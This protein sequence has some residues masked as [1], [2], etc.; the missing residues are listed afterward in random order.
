MSDFHESLSG[1]EDAPT[2]PILEGLEEFKEKDGHDS[3]LIGPYQLHF[4]R[5][6]ACMIGQNIDPTDLTCEEISVASE[7]IRQHSVPEESNPLGIKRSDIRSF[8]LIDVHNILEA[9]YM[10]GWFSLNGVREDN[11]GRS[12]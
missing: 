12:N 3:Y 1:F 10:H 5:V 7:L 11:D 9:A 4:L 2:L 8:S 6:E